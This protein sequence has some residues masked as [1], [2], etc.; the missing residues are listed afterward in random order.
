MSKNSKNFLTGKFIKR[1]K[2]FFVD[3]QLDSKKI[4]TAHCPNTGS[5]MGLLEKDNL[6]Y[7][8]EADDPN[9]K[10]KFTLEAI[11][12][13]GAMVGVNTHRANRIVEEAISNSKIS[14]LGKI[15]S[16]KREVKYGQNSRIDFLVQTKK[17]EIYVEV[18]NVTLSR[19]K[20]IAEFPD[21]VTERGLKH[22][23]ELSPLP[24]KSVRA[25]MLFLVQRDDCSKFKI[26]ADIDNKYAD[27]F[28]KVKK[29]GVEPLCYDCSF[30]RNGI[31][32][33]KKIKILN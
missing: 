4:V 23:I 13:K 18:K 28:K 16:F 26:A 11:Q 1:Y 7:L 33:N 22:L 9:R 31:S 12:S 8:T 29:M 2:R 15:L 14:E 19:D 27:T 25:V 10:L 32:V 21:A 17:E 30:G 20:S 6:V 24:A 3:V 5:M